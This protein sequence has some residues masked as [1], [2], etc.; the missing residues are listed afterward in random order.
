MN[1]VIKCPVCGKAINLVVEESAST[2]TT[3]EIE[4]LSQTLVTGLAVVPQTS[5]PFQGDQSA[6]SCEPVHQHTRLAVGLDG[7]KIPSEGEILFIS[8]LFYY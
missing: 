5:E 6:K 2:S 1:G 8:I 3:S 4:A 7:S